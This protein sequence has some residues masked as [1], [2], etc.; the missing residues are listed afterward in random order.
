MQNKV[1]FENLSGILINRKFEDLMFALFE[2]RDL[3]KVNKKKAIFCAFKECMR[4]NE[5]AL[6]MKIWHIYKGTLKQENLQGVLESLVNA[7]CKSPFL[8]E[9]KNYFLSLTIN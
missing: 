3:M 2:R 8:T 9:V 6:A 4:S 7:Y 5:L 1:N